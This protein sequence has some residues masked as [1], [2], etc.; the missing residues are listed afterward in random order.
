M[1]L[2]RLSKSYRDSVEEDPY[3]ALMGLTADLG[4]FDYLK[5]EYKEDSEDRIENV[6]E[7]S[8]VLQELVEEGETLLR[9]HGR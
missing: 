8:N 4:Y 7:L 9:V 6:S 3:M 2:R 1:S 5:K